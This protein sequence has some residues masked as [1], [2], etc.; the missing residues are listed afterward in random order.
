MEELAEESFK[1]DFLKNTEVILKEDSIETEFSESS[2]SEE[3]TITNLDLISFQK[4]LQSLRDCVLPDEAV[5][6]AIHKACEFF[7]IPEVPIIEADGA[8][9]WTDDTSLADDLFGFNRDQLMD[10]GISGEDSLTLVYTHECAHRCLKDT[11]ID[12][13]TEELACDYFSGIHAGL[14]NINLDNFEASLGCTEGGNSHPAGALR[15]QFIEHGRHTATDLIEHNSEVTLEN[16]MTRF[17]QFLIEKQ[18]LI[19]E[20]RNIVEDRLSSISSN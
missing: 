16:C 5:A 20:Y 10:M 17:N 12:S 1:E 6:N 18:G 3:S 13:W 15:V 9:V 7:G 2:F 14:N 4:T 8:C 19:T 11:F